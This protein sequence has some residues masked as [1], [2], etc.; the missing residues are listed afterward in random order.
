[1]VCFCPNYFSKIDAGTATCPWCQYHMIEWENAAY[2]EKLVRA[3]NHPDSF[4]RRRAA[5]LLGK[6]KTASAFAAL[7]EAFESASDPYLKGE[8]LRALFKI[9]PRKA[10]RGL[11]PEQLKKESVIV[12]TAWADCHPAEG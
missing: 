7:Q 1:M 4:T 3:L 6:R 11:T 9:D 10:Q 5:F 8:I 12:R 2:D